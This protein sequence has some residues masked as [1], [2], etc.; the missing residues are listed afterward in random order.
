M[1]Q[2]EQ[3][4]VAASSSVPT[5][6]ETSADVIECEECGDELPLARRRAIPGCRLCT[7]CQELE[8]RYKKRWF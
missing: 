4:L 6:S 3:R 1:A 2:Q 5:H 8:E 7:E